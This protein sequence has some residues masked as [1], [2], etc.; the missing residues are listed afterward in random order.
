MASIIY[1]FKTDLNDYPDNLKIPG[2]WIEDGDGNL[3]YV[4]DDGT[5]FDRVALP[6]EL[7]DVAKQGMTE[8]VTYGDR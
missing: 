3:R 2:R 7:R 6:P 1:D 4:N 8:A 5:P